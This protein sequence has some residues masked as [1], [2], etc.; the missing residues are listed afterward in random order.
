MALTVTA[1]FALAGCAAAPAYET[2]TALLEAYQ[3]AGGECANPR[4][5]P[6]ELLYEGARAR[7]CVEGI[8]MLVVFD[9]E[10]NANG[11]VAAVTGDADIVRG[12][13]WVV[14]GEGVAAFADELGGRE[15]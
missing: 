2:P 10:E 15:V 6:G 9:S 11:Y 7:L 13:R 3:E 4:E 8:T 1:L 12:D 14:V 5:V